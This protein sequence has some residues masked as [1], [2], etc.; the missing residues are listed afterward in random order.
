MEIKNQGYKYLKNKEAYAFLR[1]LFKNL[2]AV[3]VEEN[4]EV[5]VSNNKRKD[6]DIGGCSLILIFKDKDPVKIWSSEWAGI[7][8]LKNSDIS[9]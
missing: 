9:Y 5:Q 2:K 3:Y 1:P 6:L 8:K 7:V 4:H